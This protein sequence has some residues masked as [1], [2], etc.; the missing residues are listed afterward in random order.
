MFSS[1]LRSTLIALCF[2]AVLV[3]AASELTLKVTGP[4]AVTNVD[5]F[6]V[7][8]LLTNS[9]DET[10]HLLNDPTSSLISSDANSFRITN[11]KGASPA[12]NGAVF[13]FS[14]AVAA[15]MNTPDV[16]TVIPPGQSIKVEHD[17]SS[18]YNFTSSGEDVY[19]IEASNK[20]FVVDPATLDV[21]QIHAKQE[22]SHQAKLS[23]T[24][25]I[26]RRTTK[27]AKRAGFNG[28]SD[29]QQSNITSAIPA[30]LTYASDARDYLGNH[31]YSTPRYTQ[32]FGTYNT[33]RHSTILTH[34]TN[35]A[36]HGYNDYTYDCTCPGNPPPGTFAY[37]YAEDISTMYLCDGFWQAANTGEDS[38]AGT[39]VHESSHYAQLAGTV[40]EA[41]GHTNCENLAR[42]F[43]DL[44]AA[45]AD[46][47]EYFVE[48][49]NPTL[50]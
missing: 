20:F 29:D 36:G 40:D 32:W 4:E 5:N 18:A 16:I 44:A 47:H 38:R 37:V 33:A 30:A 41:Y 46:S 15:N 26:A 12:F 49:V 48:N 28:C 11:S 45:N 1:T 21:T 9:G 43:P 2:S 19:D 39:L 25:S 3:S 27:L 10:L 35:M 24:L 22:S 50:D 13:K 23:G 17:L 7:T 34:F 31:T 42:Y 14:P 6:K 8:T